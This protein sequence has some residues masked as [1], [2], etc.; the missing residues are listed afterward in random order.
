MFQH[1]FSLTTKR[2][3]QYKN[4]STYTMNS[5]TDSIPIKKSL[6]NFMQ[7]N[8][9]SYFGESVKF[10]FN[11]YFIELYVVQYT[12]EYESPIAMKIFFSPFL[13]FSFPIL[14]ASMAA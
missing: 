13:S 3:I 7:L 10:Y 12:F 8:N 9:A 6:I 1:F 2:T 14:S 5:T 11:C 4:P